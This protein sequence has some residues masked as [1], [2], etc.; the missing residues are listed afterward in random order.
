MRLEVYKSHN[1][2]N[3]LSC[4]SFLIITTCAGFAQ[5]SADFDNSINGLTVNFTNES[6]G[7]FNYVEYEYGDG[8]GS[9]YIND[10]SHTYA[11]A[12]VYPVCMYILDTVTFQCFSEFCDTLYLGGA[13]CGAFF[14]IDIDG[15]DADFYDESI[16]AF[17]SVWYDFGDGNGS[18]DPDP[19]HSYSGEGSYT[20]C[21][22]LFDNGTMCD[23]T[24]YTIYFTDEECEA[25]FSYDDNGLDVDFYDESTGNY[26]DVYWDFGDGFGDSEDLNPSYTYFAAGTYE[27]CLYIY[28]D[29]WGSC[30]AEYCEFV[31]VTGGGGGGG[32]CE[33]DYSYTADQLNISFTNESS[34]GLFSTWDFG[35]GSTPSFDENPT[36]LYAAPGTYEVC[37]TVV[38]PF[39]FCTDTYCEF[40]E[41][42]EYTCEPTFTYSFNETNTYTFTNTTTIGTVTS[43]EWSFGD[44]NTSA[45]TQPTY[46]Y[47]VPG[48]YNVC[49]TTFDQGNECGKTC[50]DINVYPLGLDELFSEKIQVVPNPNNGAFTLILLENASASNLSIVDLSGRTV[51]SER[52]E[53]NSKV[54]LTLDLPAG[55]YFIQLEDVKSG[56]LVTLK[57]MVQ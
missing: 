19:S 41:V 45:F 55:A 12:G 8:N 5:C 26:T 32:G 1:M 13:T 44:G 27:V 14:D 46:T 9:V 34:G 29:V 6:T 49:L 20:I 38:N 48:V 17:D 54:D 31:T 47:N 24:C 7:S 23:S 53:R 4:L 30:D 33:A 39:P 10:P 11:S 2:K 50:E 3:L 21:L 56:K 40:I 15:L 22:S 42:K 52:G 28:D 36:H 18:N 43:M 57:M 51:Y 37:V 35:D 25:D 16:G